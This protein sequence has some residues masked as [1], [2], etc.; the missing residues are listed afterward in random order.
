MADLEEAENEEKKDVSLHI[1]L[2]AFFNT[3]IKQPYRAANIV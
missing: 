1:F 2:H 3:Q